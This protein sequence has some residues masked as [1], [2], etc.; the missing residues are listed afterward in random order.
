MSEAVIIDDSENLL[1]N[2]KVKSAVAGALDAKLEKQ[3]ANP[4]RLFYCLT[5]IP[6]DIYGL[7]YRKTLREVHQ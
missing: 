3:S 2:P 7:S 1:E 6:R 5:K 4:P